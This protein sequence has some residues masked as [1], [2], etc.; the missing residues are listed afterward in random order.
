M[1]LTNIFFTILLAPVWLPLARFAMSF[2]CR[3]SSQSR[4]FVKYYVGAF[5]WATG[6]ISL[7]WTIQIHSGNGY[8]IALV[9]AWPAM[10]VGMSKDPLFK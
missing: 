9:I 3:V 7:L 2:I 10:I 4:E 8:A 1:L 6:C 5:A